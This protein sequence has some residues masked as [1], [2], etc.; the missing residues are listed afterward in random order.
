M[1]LP[2]VSTRPKRVVKAILAG[3]SAVEIC[4]VLYQNSATIIE[5]YIRF[6]N[7]W[8]D[9]KGME[10]ISQFKGILNV[11]DPKR[12]QYLLNVHSS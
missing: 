6:L 2:V 7:L 10:T 8:M 1:P 11:N 4:S 12:S 9:R 5:E 3:A